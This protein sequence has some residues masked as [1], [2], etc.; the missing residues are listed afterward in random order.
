MD[1]QTRKLRMI[2]YLLSVQDE[3]LFKSLEEVIDT[4][5]SRNKSGEFKP[6]TTDE[7]IER[8]LEAEKDIES[9]NFITQEELERE[10]KSW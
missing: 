7:I 10:S 8:A 4:L 6:L 9:G 2:E 5:K 1:L 3:G